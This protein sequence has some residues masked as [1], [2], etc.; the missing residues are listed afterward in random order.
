M[1]CWC[2]VV[3]LLEGSGRESEESDWD[4][5]G[6]WGRGGSGGKSD[7]ESQEIFFAEE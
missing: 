1:G 4:R 3:K 6:A 5:T 2:P 7:R